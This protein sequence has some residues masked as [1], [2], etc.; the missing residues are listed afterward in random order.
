MEIQ[1]WRKIACLSTYLCAHAVPPGADPAQ[2]TKEIVEEHIPAVAK[3]NLAVDNIDVFCEK[4]K[5]EKKAPTILLLT[6]CSGSFFL[7]IGQKEFTTHNSP[8]KRSL[9]DGLVD[10]KS[11]RSLDEASLLSTT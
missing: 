9:L 5:D 10:G 4:G 1:N 8:K 11:V 6:L 2:M 3:A 7:I